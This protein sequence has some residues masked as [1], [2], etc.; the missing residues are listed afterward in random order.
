MQRLRLDRQR[1]CWR[2]STLRLYMVDVGRCFFV[3]TIAIVEIVGCPLRR[4]LTDKIGGNN[5]YDK[6]DASNV[7][8]NVIKEII[9]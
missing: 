1:V 2:R 5:D 9:K 6:A 3:E 7:K 4:K 8:I